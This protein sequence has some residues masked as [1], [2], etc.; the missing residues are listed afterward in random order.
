ML[1]VPVL[2]EPDALFAPLHAP[3]AVQL[4][5]LFV[6]DHDKVEDDPVPIE[7]GEADIDTAGGLVVV[8][9][10]TLTLVEAVSLPPALLQ[11]NV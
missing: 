3:V 9:L 1:I 10:L 6:A 7:G 2:C 11:A 8:P 5:G 4:V